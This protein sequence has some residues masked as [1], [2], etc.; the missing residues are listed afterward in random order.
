MGA[1]KKIIVTGGNGQLG[2]AINKIYGDST[3]Y[4]CVNTDVGE[5]DITSVDAVVRFV[6]E[7]K[8]YAIINCAAHT[9][10]DGCET[11]V[12]NAYKINAVG[13]RNLSIAASRYQAR[14]VHISTDYVFD[15]QADTPYTEY[16]MPAPRTVYGKTKLAGENFVKEFAE[17][18]FIIR[19]A[20]LYGDGK[21]F[22]K[23]ML[24]LSEKRDRVTVVGDQ[25]GSPTSAEELAKVIAYLLPTDNFGLFHGTCE[26][27]TNWADFTRE[28]FRLAG[29]STVV[30]TVTTGQ[31]EKIAGGTV[32]P[33]PAYSV[34]DNYMLRLTTDYMFADWEKAIAEYM[35]GI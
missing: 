19:T 7:V 11:D 23:T 28:I 27:I 15:G 8:P 34:L 33:R 31:Y 18:Y 16:D 5:L 22:V 1:T 4:E 30:E 35:K 24:G 25:F 29:K 20:W 32:A 9:N 26:G 12:D 14:L 17:E 21:N 6:S 10:V 2:R 3:E 13:P